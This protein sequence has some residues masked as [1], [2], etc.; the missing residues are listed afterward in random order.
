MPSTFRFEEILTLLQEQI[1]IN[2][3]LKTSEVLISASARGL[4]GG[5]ASFSVLLE[6]SLFCIFGL[7]PVANAVQAN[8]LVHFIALRARARKIE[9]IILSNQR[10]TL[11]QTTPKN[12]N[13]SG[14]VLRRYA[15]IQGL[16]D[17]EEPLSPLERL[18]FTELAHKIAS[19]LITLSR[20]KQLDLI[21]PDAD[22]FVDRLIRAVEVLK[23]TVKRAFS[24]QLGISPQFAE[25]IA[26][27][28]T[29]QGIPADVRSPDFTEA[30][31]RQAIYRL[32][33]KII[34]YQSLRRALPNL[35]EMDVAGL[36][37]GQVMPRLLACFNEAHKIDYHAVFRE[38]VVDRLPFPGEASAE[39]RDLVDVLNTR[40]FAHLPQDVVG[41]VFER[42]I[43]PEDRHALGQYF[44]PE[45]LVDLIVAFCVRHSDDTVLDPTC[46]TGTFLIRA[47]DRKRTALGLHD[48]SQQLG[49][50]WGIDIAPF[51]AELAT[52]N[53]FRQE[54]GTSDNFPR[55]LNDDF[56]NVKPG[57]KYYFPPLKHDIPSEN[58]DSEG[59][60]TNLLVAIPQFDAILGNF[61][62]ISADRIEQHEKGYSN[63]ITLRLAED[64][65]KSYPAGFTFESKADEHQHRILREQGM[66][67]TA[68]IPKAQPV[69]ST[70]ADI[71]ISLFWHAAAFLK[72]G[73]RMGIVTSNA[74]LDVGYGYG[75]QRFFL[76]NF[77][78]IAILES[79]CEPWFQEAAVNTVV[80]IVERCESSTERDAHPVRFVRIKRPLADL[81]PWDMRLDGLRRWVGIDK[82]VQHITAGMNTS[83]DPNA[84]HST[85]DDDFRI[86][87][88]NQSA[89]RNEVNRARQTVKWGRY[90]RA[91]QV[92]FDLLK[93]AS[94]D[95]ILLR[96]IAPPSRG[97]L[98]G[99]NEFYYFDENKIKKWAIEPEFLYPLLKSPGDSD[100]ILID[101]ESLNLKV[102]VCRMTK[103]E[104]VEKAKLNALRYIEWG[105]EQT[106]KTGS[107]SGLTW[108]S[109]IEVR[110]R[111]PGWYALPTYRGRP[112]QIFFSQAFGN[113]FINKYGIRSVGINNVAR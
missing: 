111:K 46:G 15:P 14:Q 44:T 95:L 54:V 42:L 99:N 35:P 45:N 60:T 12:D 103:Q 34:F 93:Q 18:A 108:A 53:L 9:Y 112:G 21:E 29:K 69:I 38:D 74:W 86:R 8:G 5:L 13:D 92:Y 25:E 109:G 37:T 30:V 2:S 39:L 73:G 85:E 19:D 64:W 32:L 40:D 101:E 3:S 24:T 106:Y 62:Y 89:L 1:E 27:W 84:P 66:D 58:H 17:P 52:I 57:G 105:E 56:F 61:P 87:V 107:L 100:K 78:I 50:L 67:V 88:I 7:T 4:S 41:A 16:S 20:D 70:F 94:N 76:D 47:Y 43:P 28:A 81:M 48:H 98:T 90:M 75:L 65:F 71:Y 63:R 82:H 102:F 77:K 59:I 91:P 31:V 68:Y 104:L 23:P 113:R 11:L 22:Y 55:V 80:T 97:N 6:D 110:N 49:Y 96:E 79:R 51:P 10:K 36:D 33:G 83:E 26:A 72:P